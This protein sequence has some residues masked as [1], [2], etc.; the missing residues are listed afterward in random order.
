INHAP[1]AST[2]FGTNITAASGGQTFQASELF[3]ATDPDQ[4][5]LTYAVYDYT[6]GGGN[7]SVNGQAVA[8]GTARV[9][10]AA[11]FA[12][13]TFSAATSGSD[14]V[15]IAVNDTPNANASSSGWVTKELDITAPVNGFGSGVVDTLY[16][17]VALPAV[18][19]V[20]P[21]EGTAGNDVL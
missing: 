18:T 10:T 14:H 1:V 15:M 9:L 11:E 3:S 16:S 12:Q 13:T 8:S 20:N 5:V 6:P 19:V 17:P 2:P 7:F 4:D 21:I